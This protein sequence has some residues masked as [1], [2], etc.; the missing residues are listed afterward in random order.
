MKYPHPIILAGLTFTGLMTFLSGYEFW[1]EPTFVDDGESFEH[2]LEY[3]VVGLACGFVAL[4][5]PTA[6]AMRDYRNREEA[7]RRSEEALTALSAAQAS[8]ANAIESISEAFV[9]FDSDGRL[10]RCNQRYRDLYGYSEAE[11]QPGT[12]LKELG[13]IDRERGLLGTTEETEAFLKGRRLQRIQGVPEMEVQLANG[14]WLLI[15]SRAAAD[16]GVVNIQ[17]DITELKQMQA[18]LLESENRLTDAIEGLDEGFVYFD[19][20]DRLVIANSRYKDIY[21]SQDDLKI[22]D[23]FED[24]I[25]RSIAAGEVPLAVGREQAWLDRRLE[26]HRQYLRIED[27]HL[28]DGRWIKLSE[29][30]TRD[31]GSVGIRT[32]ITALKESQIEAES[33]SQAKTMFLAHMSHELRTPLNSI[34]GFSEIIRQQMFGDHVE[35]YSEYAQN[36]HYSGTLLLALINDILDISKIEANELVPEPET[37]ILHDTIEECFQLVRHNAEESHIALIIKDSEQ[38]LFAHVDPLH[39]KQILLNLLSNSIKFTPADGEISVIAER[40]EGGNVVLRVVDNGIGISASDQFKLFEPFSQID[41]A[42]V[43]GREG[44]GLGLTLVKS[45]AELN[46]GRV[47]LESAADKG[48]TVSVI[49]PAAD[50]I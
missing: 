28:A 29:R 12:S 27:Q 19:A 42:L 15:R 20:N 5:V 43:R 4:C 22:G 46:G 30:R 9:Q 31:G 39:L 16:G 6:L 23:S 11:T 3:V 48:T 18:A 34:I 1:F 33:A 14:R 44:T 38:D 7:E 17:A 21:P 13:D 41:N 47:I 32:D 49:L 2:R 8:L 50:G 24:I 26:Q 45:Y 40:E 25:R 37:V 35:S 10:I 36:I